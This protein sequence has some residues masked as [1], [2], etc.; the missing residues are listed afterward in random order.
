V[1]IVIVPARLHD[2]RPWP[3]RLA[4][5]RLAGADSQRGVA[6]VSDP[7]RLRNS[8]L[9][10]DCFAFPAMCRAINSRRCVMKLKRL[11][12]SWGEEVV[13]GECARVARA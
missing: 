13:I 11:A 12:R 4:S 3:G 7:A 5:R 10:P 2:S 1:A 8:R 9:W 6:I